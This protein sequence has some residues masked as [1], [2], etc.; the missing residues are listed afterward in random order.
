MPHDPYNPA[1]AKGGY[2]REGYERAC[3]YWDAV[4]AELRAERARPDFMAEPKAAI[5]AAEERRK[6]EAFMLATWGELLKAAP[7]RVR[8]K[9]E[10]RMAAMGGER[11]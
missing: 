11:D 1:W 6:R 2:T 7:K 5:A 4:R 8:K 9:I 3:A 10:A